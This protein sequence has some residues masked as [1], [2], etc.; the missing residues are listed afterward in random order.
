MQNKPQCL[1]LLWQLYAS[2]F[3]D[4]KNRRK[5]ILGQLCWIRSF[6]RPDGFLN[7]YAQVWKNKDTK[8]P[9]CGQASSAVEQRKKK[10]NFWVRDSLNL[11]CIFHPQCII[12]RLF[13]VQ[14]SCRNSLLKCVFVSRLNKATSFLDC[15]LK[16]NE[17]GCTP[18]CCN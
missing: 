17:I 13:L 9:L 12:F 2:I 11:C 15:Y 5:P 18:S 3:W 14:A 4:E 1:K 10:K 16:T 8:I 6:A 7:I